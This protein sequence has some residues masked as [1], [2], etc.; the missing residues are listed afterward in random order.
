MMDKN[1]LKIQNSL[2]LINIT[3]KEN[4]QARVNIYLFC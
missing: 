3:N 4:T 1:S 2:Y